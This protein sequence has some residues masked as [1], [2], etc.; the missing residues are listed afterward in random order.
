MYFSTRLVMC[1]FLASSLKVIQ[2]RGGS[3]GTNKNFNKTW[4]QY[5][6]GFGN[7]D[8]EFWLGN[9]LIHQL[10]KSGNMKLM[11]ELEAYNGLRAWAEY[12]TFRWNLQIYDLILQN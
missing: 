12:D 4:D 9:E 5:K 10:T 8:K 1:H 2:K 6:H 3:E 7:Y 11:V